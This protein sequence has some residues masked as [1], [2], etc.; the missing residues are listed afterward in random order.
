MSDTE[1]NL[2]AGAV[3]PSPDNA[4]L[5]NMFAE[6]Q[7]SMVETT[8]FLS[9]L[10][11][12]RAS[13]AVDSEESQ[14]PVPEEDTTPASE[15]ANNHTPASEEVHRVV[16]DDTLSILGGDDFEDNEDLL[17]EIDES[18]RPSDSIGPPIHEK[19]AKIVNDKF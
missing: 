4:M 8:Q 3:A 15:E 2:D 17:D 6:L 14:T 5:F 12:E 19:I 7:K 1:Q 13:K 9:E 18:L 10:R 16:N 11:A